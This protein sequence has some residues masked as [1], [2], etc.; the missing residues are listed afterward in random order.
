MKRIVTLACSAALVA[1]ATPRLA[2]A[3]IAG[4]P[5]WN[6][7]KGG[8]GLTVSGDLGFPDS[9]GG[10]GSTY[11]GRV[12]VGLQL[13]TL[14]ATVGVRNPKGPGSNVTE[15]GGAAAFR[16]IGGSL[17]PVAVNLQGGFAGFSQSS[18][19]NTRFTGALG[20][21]L[22]LPTPGLNL[23]PWVAPGFRVNHKGASGPLPSSTKT[24]FGIAGGV[25]LGLG[26]IGLHAGVDYEKI[27]G[28]GHTTTFGIGVH[29]GLRVPMGM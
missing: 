15:Y 16:V 1:A 20:V 21:A 26:L 14:S 27:E 17:L 29:A 4:M 3:Q 10:K 24:N 11:A 19:T 9:T 12:D 13:L 2:S 7:P 6:S 8:T 23:E 22:S 18:V 28:G 25:N 5:V